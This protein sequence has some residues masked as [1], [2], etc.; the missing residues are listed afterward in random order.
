MALL[1]HE[2]RYEDK[3]RQRLRSFNAATLMHKLPGLPA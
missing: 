1:P 2:A 3:A